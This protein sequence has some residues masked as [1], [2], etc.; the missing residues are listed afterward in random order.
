VTPCSARRALLASVASAAFVACTDA[1]TR[2]AYDLEAGAKGLRS[3]AKETSTVDHVPVAA[4]EGCPGPYT[5]QLSRE[6]ALVVWC[7]EAIGAPSSGSHTTTYHLNFVSV[8][9]TL[10]V[11]KDAGEHTEIDLRKTG[12]SISVVGLR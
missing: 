4:P 3:S 9:E 2:I 8:P 5:V 1:A 7:Q 12:D 6:S 10:I 11:H